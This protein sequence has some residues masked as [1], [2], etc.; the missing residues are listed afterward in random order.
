MTPM[1]ITAS[2]ETGNQDAEGPSNP[3]PETHRD[4]RRAGR[5]ESLDPQSLF[6]RLYA[7]RFTYYALA[8]FI[9]FYVFTIRSL[10]RCFW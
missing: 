3:D 6:G 7:F 9:L 5:I 10:N 1:P 8:A 2:Q 4:T